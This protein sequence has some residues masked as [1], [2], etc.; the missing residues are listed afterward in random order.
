[1]HPTRFS[2][3]PKPCGAHDIMDSSDQDGHN[4]MEAKLA[5]DA[6]NPIETT[7]PGK[8]AISDQHTGL[9]PRVFLVFPSPAAPAVLTVYVPDESHAICAQAA[10]IA[11]GVLQC[12]PEMKAID[13]TVLYQQVANLLGPARPSEHFTRFV[14]ATV[15]QG[16]FRGKFAF[17]VGTNKMRQRRAG[18]LAAAIVAAKS[19][20][21]F[22]LRNAWHHTFASM[23]VEA[24]ALLPETS[25]VDENEDQDLVWL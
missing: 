13:H 7:I 4:P 16:P 14:M 11:M 20:S 24:L 15:Q 1:M 3:W 25:K 5:A 2:D 6:H 23:C 21:G 10:N 8:K 12:R 18:N 9:E 19:P 22:H 17:G